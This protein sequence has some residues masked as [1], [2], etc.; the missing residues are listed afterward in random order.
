MLNEMQLN[1][2]KKQMLSESNNSCVLSG[3]LDGRFEFSHRVKSEDFYSNTIKVERTSGKIDEIPIIVS[4]K[5]K[6]IDFAKY[7][8]DVDFE[9][10][11]RIGVFYYT[12]RGKKH[13][14]VYVF[15]TSC[16]L[17]PEE[18]K[19]ENEVCL[20]GRVC[21]KTIYRT[22]PR[23]KEITEICIEVKNTRGKNVYIPCIAWNGNA[24]E[25]AEYQP[26]DRIKIKGRIQS[27][28]Y[29]KKRPENPEE[30]EEKV[31]YEVSINEL[32]RKL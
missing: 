32:E 26:G 22:T 1:E 2:G 14:K 15:V 23:G 11:G 24:L 29:L 10:S 21:K 7:Y 28:N 19:D 4:G 8:T 20:E 3:K 12:E 25:S 17:Q 18:M 30:V 27:R 31:T 6:E 9:L 16:K 5:D 13:S